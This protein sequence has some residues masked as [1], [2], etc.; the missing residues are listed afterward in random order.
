MHELLAFDPKL[1]GLHTRDETDT[2]LAVRLSVA[3]LEPPFKVAVTVALPFVRTMPATARKVPVDD[4]AR[5]V[6]AE[7][8]VSNR[9]LL[10]SVIALP[11]VGAEPVN[12]IVQVLI[13]PASKVV[14]VQLNDDTLTGTKLIVAGAELPLYVAATVA[15]RLLLSV[16]LVALKLAV[17]APAATVTDDG[18]VRAA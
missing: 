16:P 10:A 9:L 18:T 7:G 11:P 14:G 2:L 6:V 15:V 3:L 1:V 12:V 5:I 13:N 17:V 4:P 8:T